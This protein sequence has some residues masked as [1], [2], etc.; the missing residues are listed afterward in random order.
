MV[1]NIINALGGTPVFDSPDHIP[2]YP[3]RA[4][5]IGGTATSSSGSRHSRSTW[6]RTRSWSSSSR[7]T[8]CSS[9][10]WPPCRRRAD[11]HR[12]VLPHD[13]DHHRRPRRRRLLRPPRQSGRP[14]TA[15]SPS[16]TSPPPTQA[17]DT[18][19]DQGEGTASS[20]IESAGT[21]CPATE[22]RPLLPVRRDRPRPQA[23]PQPGRRAVGTR[24]ISSSS[25][26]ATTSPSRPEVLAA[27]VNPTADGYPEG[28]A[29]RSACDDFNAS[30]TS[31]LKTLQ[32]VFT[33]Q[34]DQLSAFRRR[35]QRHVLA[36]D[37]RPGR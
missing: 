5:G 35:R 27:P 19:I 18:I 23:D 1:A 8:R 30:Y 31:M 12:P 25:S 29:A 26:A 4:A 13:P 15:S 3:Q 6:S 22:L 11:D 10:P 7:S 9:T 24:P 32:T 17:I 34:P 28:S 20:P 14:S 21:T 36:P 16:P 33:G 2:H 37:Q